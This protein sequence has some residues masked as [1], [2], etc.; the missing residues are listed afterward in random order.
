MR[1]NEIVPVDEQAVSLVGHVE[2]PFERPVTMY[3]GTVSAGSRL[4]L[5][6]SLNTA[7]RLLG[8]ERRDQLVVS[9][10]APLDVTAFWCPWPE[11]DYETLV[12]LRRQMEERYTFTSTNKVLSAIR[13]VLKACWHLGLMEGERYR[14]AIEVPAARGENL[15]AGREIKPGEIAALLHVCAKDTSLPGRRDAA[16]IATLAGCGLRRAEIAP[17]CIGD[18]NPDERSLAVR[19]KR[20][21]QRLVYAPDGT[22]AAVTDW[23]TARRR[24]Q[25]T[26]AEALLFVRMHKGGGLT[27]YPLGS[28]GIYTILIARQKEAGIAEFTPHD[29]RRTFVG[30]LLDAGADIATVQKLA[31]HANVATTAR[32]DRRPEAV[33]KKASG[34]LH[35]PYQR[36]YG[37]DE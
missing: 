12:T 21:K 10:R 5:L 15:P 17:L 3:L 28:Q 19:G 33:K 34:L 11:L 6:A 35:I 4:T 25:T 20:N 8:T 9:R 7:A 16:L 13:G 18:W 36:P 29:L 32:Y 26:P 31:G 1:R 27:S 30:D 22:F 24:L 23:L 2:A 37:S 14:L